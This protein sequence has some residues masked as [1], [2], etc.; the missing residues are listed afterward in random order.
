MKTLY[1]LLTL[2]LTLGGLEAKSFSVEVRSPQGPVA[3]Q[4]VDFFIFDGNQN[5]ESI[6]RKTNSQGRALFSITDK[7]KFSVAARTIYQGVSYFTDVNFSNVKSPLTLR[8]YPA[9]ISSDALKIRDLQLFLEPVEKSLRVDQQWTVFNPTQTTII[10]GFRVTLPSNGFDLQLQQGF[11]QDRTSFEGNDLVVTTPL[12]PGESRFGL[13]YSI[14]GKRT[15]ATF[16]PQFSLPVEHLSL[17]INQD[18][19]LK[20]KNFSAAGRRILNDEWVSLYERAV[21]PG[22]AL[23]IE[24]SGLPLGLRFSQ[25][26][27]WIVV[28]LLCLLLWRLPRP[29]LAT[30]LPDESKILDELI[31]LER[32]RREKILSES[33]YQLRRL[34]LLERLMNAYASR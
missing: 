26:L 8:V 16:A 31:Y 19:S 5:Q 33:E 17:G 18:L 23:T 13:I 14:E 6:T 25:W 21:E 1:L 24:V 27:P 22:E 3:N 9:T 32:A 7:E 4:E 34:P 29:Q 11:S 10:S 30:T 15:R 28:I 12:L 2:L 20:N